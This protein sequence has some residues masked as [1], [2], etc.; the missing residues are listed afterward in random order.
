MS[1]LIINAHASS[2]FNYQVVLTDADK[3]EILSVLFEP[4]LAA[5]PKEILLSPRTDAK[6]LLDL[7]GLRFKQLSYE[8]EKQVAEYYELRDIKIHTDYIEIWLS[9]GNYCKKTSVGYQFRKEQGKW[10]AKTA[11]YGESFTASGTVCAGCKTG[12][13]LIYRVD[14]GT[15]QATRQEPGDLR[16]TGKAN[17]TSCTR[18]DAKYIRCKVDLSLDFSNH[19]N[20]PI[21]ILQPHGEYEFWQGGASLAL[22]KADSEAYHYVYSSSAWPSIYDTEEY[23]LLAE[24]LDQAAPPANLTRVI[25]PG[26]SWSWKTTIQLGLAE[27]NTCSGTTGVQIGWREIKKLA[28]PVWLEVSYEMWPFNVENF[29]RDLGGKLR[30]RWKS[31][32]ILYLEEKSNKFWFAHL[33]SEP[34]ELDFQQVELGPGSVPRAVAKHR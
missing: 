1:I 25:A 7:P 33:T 26:E 29:K 12:S 21:I 3:K 24:R 32:G 11:R 28:A 17:A 31:H 14:T 10:R 30:E 19:G 13:G 2:T 18:S 27:E 20:R 9:K 22:T 8:E 16:L 15:P 5:A 34:L 6:W 4:E 23:R